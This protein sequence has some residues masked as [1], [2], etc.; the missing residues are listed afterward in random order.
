M[1][2]AATVAGVN[3][4]GHPVTLNYQTVGGSTIYEAFGSTVAGPI[5]GDTFKA[6]A[7]ILPDEDFQLP[8]STTVAGIRVPVPYV[9]S[10]SSVDNAR[11][12]IEGAGLTAADGGYVDSS[13]PRG[14]ISYIYPSGGNSLSPGDT[15]TYYVSDGSP[16]PPPPKHHNGGGGNH[17]GGHGGGHGNHGHGH[18]HH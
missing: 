17:G 10:C 1:A 7:P 18:G 9:S 13:C 11:S 14:T 16:P 3:S 6:I 5:W 15:V 12:V 2:G 8:D 4:A